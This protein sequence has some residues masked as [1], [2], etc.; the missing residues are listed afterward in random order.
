VGV[1][2]LS[3]SEEERKSGKSF[4]TDDTDEEQMTQK[5]A[6]KAYLTDDTDGAQMTPNHATTEDLI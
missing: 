4:L 5:T 1:L 2:E 3:C 6:G